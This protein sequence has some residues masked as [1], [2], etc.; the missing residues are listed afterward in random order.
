MN[1]AR[2]S[3]RAQIHP[4]ALAIV[5][6]HFKIA[7]GYD[8][9]GAPNFTGISADAWH[10]IGQSRNYLELLDLIRRDYPTFAALV[11]KIWAKKVGRLVPLIFNRTQRLAWD[12]FAYRMQHGL[13]LFFVIL[14][15]RQLGMS[16]LINGWI[17]WQVWRTRDIE[18]L[19]VTHDKP[20]S[21][22][23]VDRLRIFHEELP[24]VAGIARTLR[25]QT[26]TARVP[27]EELYYNE[28]RSK[29]STVVAKQAEAR[30]RSTLHNHLAEFA[31][32][33]EASEL[34]GALMP[35]LPA[36]GSSARLQ[37]SVVIES[38][39]NGK[40]DFYHQWQVAID[41]ESEWEAL[42]FPWYVAEDEYAITPPHGWKMSDEQR[43]WAANLA[44]MR[45]KIDGIE[46]ITPAQVYWYEQMF[47][48]ECAGN[49]DK[50]DAEYPSDAE[51]CFLL[52]SRSVFKADMR[53]LQ[54]CVNAAERRA[55]AEF[56]KREMVCAKNFLRGRLEYRP[57]H[58]PFEGPMTIEQT[59]LKP[60]FVEDPAGPLWLWEPPLPQHDYVIGTDAAFGLMD[61][62]NSVSCVIDATTGR[63]VA[64]YAGTIPPEQLADDTVALGWYYN[65]ALL[66]PEIN[67]IGVV[68][69]KRMKQLWHYPRV[70]R[71]EKWDEVGLKPNKFGHYTTN[72][73]KRVMVACLVSY[74]REHYLSIASDGLLSE[75]STFVQDYDADGDETWHADAHNRDD[76]VMALGLACIAIRQSPRLLAQF[77]K[78]RRPI[79]TALDAGIHDAPTPSAAK[80]A[81][82]AIPEKVREG[83]NH[84]SVL[85]VPANP[86]RGELELIF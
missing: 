12:R 66:Y 1:L 52:R 62:D 74:V 54:A 33:P 30:G 61:R 43:E 72:D 65:T 73:Q 23:F 48:T 38:T 78:E 13:P 27:R 84:P 36:A 64:E 10:R 39:P 29:A 7:E 42:F 81:W 49:Q 46:R 6:A 16:T 68:T 60:R 44:H 57:A 41:P 51:T 11:Q 53:Y 77:V 26:R 24:K 9:D 22:S 76:R 55:P 50:A 79:P 14:K 17:H 71:E 15:A 18:C 75:M 70:G 69:M 8:R 45:A 59:L 31:F 20:L 4:R 82:D 86:L 34:L 63:Q 25:A 19:M 3:V 37:S 56:A 2:P 5:D 58:S 28:T 47:Y 21:Y 80:S 83:L 32:Y 40:N 67:S 35:Q 85:A